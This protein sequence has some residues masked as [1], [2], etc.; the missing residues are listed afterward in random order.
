MSTIDNLGVP[1]PLFSE[2]LVR[3]RDLH[4]HF[5]ER[6]SPLARVVGRKPASVLAVNAV[7]LDIN[8]GEVL[9]LVGESGSGKTTIGRAIL[10]LGPITSG[11][12]EFGGRDITTV[13]G[14]RLKRLRQRIQ[15]VSQDP[16]GSLSPRLTVAQLL[17]E[18]YRAHDIPREHRYTVG[19]LL[20]MVELSPQLAERHPH[21]LSGGQARRVGI[22]RALSLHPEFLVADEPTS[23]LDVSAAAK[24]LNL[25]KTLR[26]EHGLTMLMITHNLNI[27]DFI[28]DRLAVAYLG[29]IAEIGPATQVLDQPRHPY[30]I[31]LLDAVSE[32]DPRA[33]SFGRKLL[34]PGEIPSPRNPPS[35]CTFHTRCAFAEKLSCREVVPQLRLFSESQQIACHLAEQIAAQRLGGPPQGVNHG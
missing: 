3:V 20:E 22:A 1:I 16:H 23:G 31:A 27:V 19:E 25:L 35:G 9:A 5:A 32:P 28:A 24:V 2:P 12:I 13:K 18:P 11:R 15:L 29:R 14:R 6:L 10:R 30:S 33:R 26:R 7:D 8:R 21:E 4:V 17:K 34:L